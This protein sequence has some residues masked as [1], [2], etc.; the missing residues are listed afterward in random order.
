MNF[1]NFALSL[2]SLYYSEDLKT[3]TERLKFLKKRTQKKTRP[4]FFDQQ[5]KSGEIQSIISR[6]GYIQKNPNK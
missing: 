5:Q 6:L 1:H 2:N 3:V 4:E